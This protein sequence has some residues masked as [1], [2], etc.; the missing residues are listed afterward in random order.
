MPSREKTRVESPE[1]GPELIA[2]PPFVEAAA[3]WSL[4][5]SFPLGT[6]GEGEEVVSVPLT[7]PAST[8]E[9][10]VRVPSFSPLKPMPRG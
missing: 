7:T 5:A 2:Q 1:I 8:A 9:A 6:R 10:Y 4:L 3:D